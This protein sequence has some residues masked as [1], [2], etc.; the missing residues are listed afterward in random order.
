MCEGLEGDMKEETRSAII[1]EL[2]NVPM[3]QNNPLDDPTPEKK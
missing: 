3:P 1:K 2:A